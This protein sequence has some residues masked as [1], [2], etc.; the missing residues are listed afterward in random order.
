MNGPDK[1]GKEGKKIGAFTGAC[2][3]LLFEVMFENYIKALKLFKR[4]GKQ[5]FLFPLATLFFASI[6]PRWS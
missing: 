6:A 3:R 5:L 1:V 4:P 2:K